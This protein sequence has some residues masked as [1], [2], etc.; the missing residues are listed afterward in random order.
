M[1][2]RGIAVPSTLRCFK[3]HFAL[4]LYFL[5]FRSCCRYQMHNHNQCNQY[6]FIILFI[7]SSP[8]CTGWVWKRKVF[9]AC[10]TPSGDMIDRST[11]KAWMM[12]CSW[13]APSHVRVALQRNMPCDWC[14]EQPMHRSI[15]RWTH[16]QGCRL[17]TV[18]C[19]SKICQ[20]EPTGPRICCKLYGEPNRY[21]VADGALWIDGISPTGFRNGHQKIGAFHCASLGNGLIWWM[22]KKT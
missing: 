6:V 12:H 3:S 1:V 5:E 10:V 14:C 20:S 7:K 19:N 21:H 22:A 2:T 18:A 4:V 13:R 8:H 11:H 9:T 16:A 15:R 17:E